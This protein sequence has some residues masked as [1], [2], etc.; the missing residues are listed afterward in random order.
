[1]SVEPAKEKVSKVER[2]CGDGDR[3]NSNRSFQE[4]RESYEN[5]V[6]GVEG[7]PG[8]EFPNE[9]VKIY[10]MK[11]GWLILPIKRKI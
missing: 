5:K 10:Q 6:P 8:E 3:A 7:S 9:T 1:M 4:S 11:I 2:E